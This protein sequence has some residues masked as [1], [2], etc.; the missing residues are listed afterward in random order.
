MFERYTEKARRAV[1]FSRYEASQFGS[2]YI[3]TEHLLLGI[4]RENRRIVPFESVAAI[5]KEIESRAVIP[6][7]VSTSVDLPISNECKRVMAYGAEEAERLGHKH[8]GTEHLLLGLLREH[9]CFADE[10]LRKQGFTLE[11]LRARIAKDPGSE[12]ESAFARST[13][14]PS[15]KRPRLEQSVEIHG[16]KLNAEHIRDRVQ[17]M[18]AVNWQWTRQAWTSKD[19]VM[20][21]KTNQISFDTSLAD[22][23]NDIHKV[24][25]GW[26][27]D[28]CAICRW[29][30]WESKDEAARG[31]G[32]TNGR[33]WLCIECYA[34]FI[35]NQFFFLPSYPE[36]T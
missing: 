5:R 4:L 8:I 22:D 16:A 3:E 13:L 10:I 19:I 34:K 30:L 15:W 18:R 12:T 9:G 32:Y 23:A 6:E 33:D 31:T 21:H 24:Q 1:F 11:T 2:P 14:Q 26:K 36:M 29:E 28:Y 25:G 27:K 17:V 20:N 7:R 35:V